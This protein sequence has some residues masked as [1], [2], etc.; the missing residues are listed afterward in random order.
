MSHMK[1]SK[2]IVKEEHFKLYLEEMII[3]PLVDQSFY[4]ISLK[5]Y[6]FDFDIEHEMLLDGQTGVQSLDLKHLGILQSLQSPSL[7]IQ[8][9]LRS[10]CHFQD[11]MMMEETKSFDMNLESELL[12]LF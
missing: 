5:E 9:K 3:L 7:L 4:S 10:Q 12:Q 11:R 8:M 6:S 2:M 1:F